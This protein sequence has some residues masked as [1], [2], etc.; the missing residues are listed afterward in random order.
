MVKRKQSPFWSHWTIRSRKSKSWKRSRRDWLRSRQKR[1]Q[2]LSR[3]GSK[4]SSKRPRQNVLSKMRMRKRPMRSSEKLNL[5]LKEVPNRTKLAKLH[6][7]HKKTSH[8]HLNKERMLMDGIIQ[9]IRPLK[10]TMTKISKSS[11]MMRTRL[12]TYKISNSPSTPMMLPKTTFHIR[13]IMAMAST[14]S[15]ASQISMTNYQTCSDI[16]PY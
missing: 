8:D 10:E 2:S 14:R 16:N 1:T 12:V 3:L 7:S 6:Q 5:T 13:Q 15:L 9:T 11:S 4:K